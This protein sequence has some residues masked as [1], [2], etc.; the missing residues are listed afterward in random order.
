MQR[1]DIIENKMSTS[2]QLEELD[3]KI[4][5]NVTKLG[6][7]VGIA[8]KSLKEKE[9]IIDRIEQNP[10][11]IAK[12]EEV[13]NVLGLAFSS[14]KTSEEVSTSKNL[15][16]TSVPKGPKP[17]KGAS[18][19]KEKGDLKMISVHP[20]FTKIKRSLSWTLNS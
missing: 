14:I 4:H 9:S 11:R 3:K 5:N 8:L 10:T 17:S 12:L 6:S 13:I 1:L 15:K 19:S 2:Q 18:S 20:N 7:L 16:L